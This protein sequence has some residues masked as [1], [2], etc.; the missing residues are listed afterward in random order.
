MAKSTRIASGALPQQQPMQM[1]HDPMP[2]FVD[3]PTTTDF[4]N[5]F[6]GMPATAMSISRAPMPSVGAP[7]SPRKSYQNH[8][9]GASIASQ[10]SQGYS[11][12]PSPFEANGRA[13][14]SP[15]TPLRDHANRINQAVSLQPGPAPMG[16]MQHTDSMQKKQPMMSKFKPVHQKPTMDPSI[17][18]GRENVHPAL[19]PASGPRVNMNIEPSY[20]K[21]QTKRTLLEAAPIKKSR[22][23]SSSSQED[24][25][26]DLPQ[27]VLPPHDSFPPIV[28]DG[29]K[30]GHSYA[31]LI[32]MAI[33]RSKDRRL[34]LSQIYKW[35]QDTY[36][37]FRQQDASGWQNSIR[38]N[39][40]LNKSFVKEVRQK[41]D[42]GKGHY[43]IIQAGEEGQFLKEKP[44]RKV[45]QNGAIIM[46]TRPDA[47]PMEF[48][49]QDGLPSFP[50]PILPAH[51]M[52]YPQP[53]LP[54]SI[55]M[56]ATVP[57]VSS[58][59][60]IPLSDNATPEDQL[61]KTDAEGPVD[62]AYSPEEMHSSPPVP[63]HVNRSNTPPPVSRAPAS[64]GAR[65]HKRKFASMDDSGYISSLESSAMRP[66]QRLSS[67][68]DRPR[69]KRGRA[70][71]E[72]ARLRASSYDSPTKARSHGMMPPSS[73]PCRQASDALQMPP[74]VTPA[75]NKRAAALMRPPPSVSPHTSLGL[76]RNNMKAMLES[77]VRRASNFNPDS[78]PSTFFE[79]S[80]FGHDFMNAHFDIF[81]DEET[82][83]AI[84]ETMESFFNAANN[85][86]PIKRSAKK[87]RLERTQS[88][89]ALGD[90]TGSA[91]NRPAM[92]SA[93]AFTTFDLYY[94]TPS[95]ILDD[96]CSP[97]KYLQQSPIAIQAAASPS[98]GGQWQGV[99]EEMYPVVDFGDNDENSGLDLLNGGF[100]RI[101][102]IKP[103]AAPAGT[104]KPPLG[105]SFTTNF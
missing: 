90:I 71:E 105:R 51:S 48:P 24:K 101:G 97:S 8:N 23:S 95:K 102:S 75:L 3:V 32:A 46:T 17:Q 40:S 94:E 20:Q 78:L 104:S 70:E 93:P 84:G 33:M 9:R 44:G 86:S 53:S 4:Q 47:T 79:P 96:T 77:P 45:P 7:L 16:G 37:F 10:M 2:N 19:Q 11:K 43:W 103:M 52:G 50:T 63:R 89:N 65:T 91:S 98:K 18:Y 68:A 67:E 99:L 69:I 12:Q 61:V 56:A 28:D 6:Y 57:E 58:D 66:N 87:A 88:A 59:A 31:T 62:N 26:S 36:S 80:L 76:H 21:S 74:P 29:L 49:A 41:G 85:G 39:L 64:S 73:S 60:T 1:Y 22:P 13:T 55:S 25:D 42:P 100:A 30:P 14:I 92:L 83:E 35:I 15:L 34:T 54:A 38:H 27:M 81:Q 72:I 5:G 82:G